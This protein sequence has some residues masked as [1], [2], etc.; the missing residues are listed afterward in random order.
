MNLNSNIDKSCLSFSVEELL[1]LQMHPFQFRQINAVEFS[2][3]LQTASVE[4]YVMCYKSIGVIKISPFYIFPYLTEIRSIF[5]ILWTDTVYFLN[6]DNGCLP[7]VPAMNESLLFLPV[8]LHRYPSHILKH[9]WRQPFQSLSL[10]D[11][12]VII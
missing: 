9:V 11:L 4:M 5:C 6:T 3:T 7:N 10:S 2:R 1:C 8:L 12:S